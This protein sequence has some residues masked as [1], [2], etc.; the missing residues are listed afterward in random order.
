MIASP[1]V[2]AGR[3]PVSAKTDLL[4]WLPD[5][6]VRQVLEECI[7]KEVPLKRLVNYSDGTSLTDDRPVNEYFLLRRLTSALGGTLRFMH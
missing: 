2:I 4:E 1:E 6:T 5:L 7:A 3:M